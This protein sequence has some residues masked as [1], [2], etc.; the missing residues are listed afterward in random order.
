MIGQ[1][2]SEVGS[3]ACPHTPISPFSH[4]HALGSNPSLL[5][6][7]LSSIFVMPLVYRVPP[8]ETA[9]YSFVGPLWVSPLGPPCHLLLGSPFSLLPLSSKRLVL[10]LGPPHWAV[11]LKI[12][13]KREQGT[14]TM[15]RYITQQEILR[16]KKKIQQKTTPPCLASPTEPNPDRQYNTCPSAPHRPWPHLSAR[17]ACPPDQPDPS[18]RGRRVLES[19][20]PHLSVRPTTVPFLPLLV[21]H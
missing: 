6:A 16:K 15:G 11:S 2:Q 12:L 14:I 1:R 13:T 17:V 3:P 9:R 18:S 20:R 21:V 7:R 5:P 19:P 4:G 10:P 8:T